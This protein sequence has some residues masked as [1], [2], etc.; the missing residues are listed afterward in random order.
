MSLLTALLVKAPIESYAKGL[1]EDIAKRYPPLLDQQP[2]K[3]PSATRLTRIIEDACAK[4]VDF[5]AQHR[6]GWLGK[7]AF[8]N[9]FRWALREKGYQQDF[10]EL[11]TEA[12]I[13][14]ISR[15]KKTPN[16][17]VE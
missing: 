17:S 13:V 5:Q 9:A 15:P 11:A 1:A 8:G 12:L 2:G 6:L 3:R 7:A 14:L 10:V 16:S 4:A